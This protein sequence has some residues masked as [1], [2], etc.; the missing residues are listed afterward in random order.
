M[1]ACFGPSVATPYDLA[2]QATQL[3]VH[4]LADTMVTGCAEGGLATSV[5]LPTAGRRQGAARRS[6]R[7]GG[8]PEG[9]E[10]MPLTPARGHTSA[11]LGGLYELRE[12]M[13]VRDASVPGS[14]EH[15]LYTDAALHVL[16]AV[17]V[18]YLNK[19]MT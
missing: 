8:G 11:L 16:S 19:Y 15:T 14:V 18:V 13:R 3:G 10:V 12:R 9:Y 4:Q 5:A 17:G 1:G 7:R 2:D 6:G